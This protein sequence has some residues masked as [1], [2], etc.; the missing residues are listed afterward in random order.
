MLRLE[1]NIFDL[2]IQTLRR[3]AIGQQGN[4]LGALF[5]RALNGAGRPED[6]SGHRV[7][8]WVTGVL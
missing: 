3:Y 5:E 7:T 1:A 4:L 8:G 2:S 6:R